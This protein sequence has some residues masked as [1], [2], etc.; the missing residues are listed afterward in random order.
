MGRV[1]C[2]HRDIGISVGGKHLIGRFQPRAIFDLKPRPCEFL[3]A[4]QSTV[5]CRSDGNFDLLH[6]VQPMK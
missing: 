2:C 3:S 4:F 5:V 6:F 1:D